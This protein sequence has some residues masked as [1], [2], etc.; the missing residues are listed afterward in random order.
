MPLMF[1]L[2][3]TGCSMNSD[4][5]NRI[6]DLEAQVL[7]LQQSSEIDSESDEKVTALEGKLFQLGCDTA[8]SV[9]I[10]RLIPYAFMRSLGVDPLDFEIQKNP[11]TTQA[12]YNEDCP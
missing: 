8:Q 3:L 4:L 10:E 1:F 9:Q 5:E 7:K 11:L 2:I 12:K 6:E